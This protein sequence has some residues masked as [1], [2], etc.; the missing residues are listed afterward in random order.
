[1]TKKKAVQKNMKQR[2]HG[3]SCSQEPAG[4]RAQ[5]R[6]SSLTSY[7]IGGQRLCSLDTQALNCTGVVFSLPFSSTR[8]LF[9]RF[10]SQQI[11][12][13]GIIPSSCGLQHPVYVHCKRLVTKP[14]NRCLV[15]G[16]T[17]KKRNKGPSSNGYSAEDQYIISC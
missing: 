3:A 4:S 7:R 9:N 17:T 11:K 6:S 8:N 16:E 14:E 1:M 5:L 12:I 13:P 15:V 10:C 2:H